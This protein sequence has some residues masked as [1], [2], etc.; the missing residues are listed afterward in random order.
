MRVFLVQLLGTFCCILIADMLIHFRR[1]GYVHSCHGCWIVFKLL[2]FFNVIFP[3]R[4]N[5]RWS[6]TP[7]PLQQAHVC[8][9]V[10]VCVFLHV[11]R[12]FGLPPFARSAAYLVFTWA[13]WHFIWKMCVVLLT[14]EMV[15]V[16]GFVG[17]FGIQFFSC[18]LGVFTVFLQPSRRITFYAQ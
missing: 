12:I 8:V 6:D 2:F 14:L 5:H 18:W 13:P 11:V 16:S 15:G 10:C 9:C 3:S 1:V 17:G 4:S 7:P